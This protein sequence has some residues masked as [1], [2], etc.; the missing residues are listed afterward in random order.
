MTESSPVPRPTWTPTSTRPTTPRQRALLEQLEDLFLGEGFV[1][2]T[3]GD[4]VGRVRCSKSTLYA[5]ASSKEQL[6][7]RVVAN[8]FIGATERIENKIQGTTDARELLNTYLAGVSEQLNR[9]STQFM[10][11]VAGFPPA[12]SVY[13]ANS[14][15]AAERIRGFITA[16]VAAGVF[17]EVHASLIAEMAGLLIEGIQ[18]GVLGGRAGVSDAEAFRALSELLLGGLA[19]ES[20]SS[21]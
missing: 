17:R 9:A 1:H 20:E 8:F 19:A 4:L 5:L 15:A 14:E 7:T 6:A 18:T 11:D 21:A 2:L 13:E 12:R 10:R 16:G 3:L